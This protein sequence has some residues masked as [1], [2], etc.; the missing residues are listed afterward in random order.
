[1][2]KSS[3]IYRRKVIDLKPLKLIPAVK[4]YIWGGNRL[5]EEYG[6]ESPLEKQAEAWVLS[7]HKDGESVV[8]GGRYDGMTLSQVI[9]EKGKDCLGRNAE[10]FDYFPILIKLIDAKDNLSVQ[11]HP[12]D[13]YAMENEGQYGKTEAWYIL[14]CEESAELI[15]GLQKS[16]TKQELRASIENGT[17][18]D[19]LNRV[20]V[21]KGDIFLIQSGTVHA[22]GKGILLAEIQQNSNVT[23]RVYDYGRLQNGKPRELHIDK[24]VDVI[25]LNPVLAGGK[26]QGEREELDGFCKTLL[27]SCDLFTVNRLEIEEKATLCADET[28]F[29]SLVAVD[30]NGVLMKD[31]ITMTLYK[32]ESIFVPASFGEFDILGNVTVLET[33]V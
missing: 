3:K 20:K 17:L 13:K 9:A 23:Y 21:K 31:D 19:G 8:S 27:V 18:L 32:G 4:D 11:V 24:A 26:P 22:I 28:S 1:M 10:K 29:V 6:V 30:G 33:R 14:D 16:M 2:K 25:N 15:Y 7:C 5:K 12:D